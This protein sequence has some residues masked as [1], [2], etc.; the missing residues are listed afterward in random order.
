MAS[1]WKIPSLR[2]D[3]LTGNM[4]RS[5]NQSFHQPESSNWNQ[6]A[7]QRLIEAPKPVEVVPEIIKVNST[8]VL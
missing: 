5:T 3:I 7:T 6:Q 2:Q 8:E 1:E 4:Q